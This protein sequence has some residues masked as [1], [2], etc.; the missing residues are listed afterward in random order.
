M[1]QFEIEARVDRDRPILMKFEDEFCQTY[2][3]D[4]TPEEARQA[5]AELV[6]TA[7]RYEASR[8]SPRETREQKP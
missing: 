5:A 2:V 4:L 1:R 6:E 3:F 8:E 7:D